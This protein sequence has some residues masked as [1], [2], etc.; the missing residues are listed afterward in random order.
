MNFTGTAQPGPAT[1]V[2]FGQPH[3]AQMTESPHDPDDLV[4]AARGAGR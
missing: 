2:E 1:R 4:K 3:G